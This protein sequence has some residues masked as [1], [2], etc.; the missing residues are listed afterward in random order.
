MILIVLMFFIISLYKSKI[1][2]FNENYISRSTTKK[3]NEIFVFLIL[4]SHFSQYVE[5]NKT[6]DIAYRQ[7]QL[8]M[9]QLVV[10]TFLFYS[11][12]GIMEGIKHKKRKYIDTLPVRCLRILMNFD[13]AVIIFI[14]YG[15]II[16]KKFSIIQI[17]LSLFGWSSVGNSNWYVFVIL[18]LYF[19]TFLTFKFNKD[20]FNLSIIFLL[21]LSIIFIYVLR[22]IKGMDQARWYNTILCYNAGTFFS[23]FK[24]KITLLLKNN[25]VYFIS[26]ATLVIFFIVSKEYRDELLIYELNA[27][28]FC[29]II[30][31]LSMKIELNS[32][33][34][35]FF[36]NHVF[37]IYI[38]QRLPMMIGKNIEFINQD[39]YLYFTFVFILTII[40]ALIF[41]YFI[42]KINKLVFSTY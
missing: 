20:K 6:I 10:T 29:M 37:S 33:V 14:V 17:I 21:I 16:G 11:G 19:L 4:V 12:Y 3:I 36:G 7:F 42:E 15:F 27:I 34:L 9:S 18:S 38:L 40:I 35:K 30:T 13:I 32:S 26:L 24:E 28:I 22:N 25:I 39:I 31:L 1:V 23:L 5:L 2:R 41:D 8:Y